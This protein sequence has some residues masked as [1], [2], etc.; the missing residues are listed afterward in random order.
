MLQVVESIVQ[1]CLFFFDVQLN[2]RAATDV[3]LCSSRFDKSPTCQTKLER[4]NLMK[5]VA[6]ALTVQSI[7]ALNRERRLSL[8]RQII[9]EYHWWRQYRADDDE[10]DETTVDANITP[11]WLMCLSIFLFEFQF[12]ILIWHP[13]HW[14]L[15]HSLKICMSSDHHLH[16]DPSLW[17]GVSLWTGEEIKRNQCVIESI[18]CWT[19]HSQVIVWIDTHFDQCSSLSLFSILFMLND[20]YG[21]KAKQ[22]V[23]VSCSFID[24]LLFLS[25]C[26]TR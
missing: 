21:K 4:T 14:S 9:S 1:G 17:F 26:T 18:D 15:F 24:S 25:I 20:V 8:N 22:K 2:D 7:S 10:Q 6:N 3:I 11:I 19:V 16:F 12:V 5:K 13:L 23:N